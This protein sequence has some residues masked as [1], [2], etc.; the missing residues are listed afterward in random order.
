MQ[1]GR[2]GPGRGRT[3]SSGSLKGLAPSQ[4]TP[5]GGRF[6]ATPGGPRPVL[7]LRLPAQGAGDGQSSERRSS[8]GAPTHPCRTG[9]GWEWAGSP[10]GGLLLALR[11]PG[12][13]PQAPPSQVGTRTL[14]HAEGH[15]QE[16]PQPQR[17]LQRFS[18]HTLPSCAGSLLPTPPR[19]PGPSFSRP[20]AK[21]D[22]TSSTAHSRAPERDPKT[23]PPRP[24]ARE[25]VQGA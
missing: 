19:A 10:P 25:P 17:Q 11:F 8:P 1:T 5:L 9:R 20:H 22:M 4:Q 13:R 12:P 6:L 24:Q 15:W 18:H 14:S 3:G 16:G 21:L 7:G 23:R 2:A